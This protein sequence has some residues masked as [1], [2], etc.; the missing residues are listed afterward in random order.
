MGFVSI[1]GF[2][3]SFLYYL[4]YAFLDFIYFFK[5]ASSDI[6][7]Q[8]FMQLN[9]FG[10]ISKRIIYTERSHMSHI[11]TFHGFVPL[12]QHLRICFAGHLFLCNECLLS[13]QDSFSAMLIGVSLAVKWNIFPTTV[14]KCSIIS[15][16]EK[17]TKEK[18]I[19]EQPTYKEQLRLLPQLYDQAENNSLLLAISSLHS[20]SSRFDLHITPR[21]SLH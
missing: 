19:K 7:V 5:T 15:F 1:Y 14:F 16:E 12:C 9:V 18:K 17:V 8:N 13:Y 2:T 6:F 20:F 10:V 11:S 21:S 4:S 3:L